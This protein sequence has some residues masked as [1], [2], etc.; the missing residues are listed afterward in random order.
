MDDDEIIARALEIVQARTSAK[1]GPT[2]GQIFELYRAEHLRAKSWTTREPRLRAFVAMFGARDA[3]G[4]RLADWADYRAAR[5]AKPIASDNP[6]KP[7]RYY[8]DLTINQELDWAKA[9]LNWAVGAGKLP[10][11][12]LA[13]AKRVKAPTRRQTS[14]GESDVSVFLA[15]LNP[16][17][18]VLVLAA[19]DAGM[20]RN[21]IRLLEWSWCDPDAAPARIHLPGW[22]TKNGKP[23]DVP[24]T[25]RLWAAIQAVPRHMRSP[26]VLTNLESGEPFGRNT[27][28][29]WF[30]EISRD[31][32]VKAAP[33][34]GNVHL[35]D[36]RHTF[37]TQTA[38]RIGRIDVVSKLL[39][40]ATLTQ[41][42]TYVQISDDD[43]E[44]ALSKIE[45]G[46]EKDQRKGP[47][48]S[49]AEREAPAAPA[50]ARP[51]ATSR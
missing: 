5:K 15:G 30:R 39:G 18:R 35:H 25:R 45:A 9:M 21:E 13:A 51:P 38:R 6:D 48:R 14:P 16:L 19:V 4:L 32:G 8:K 26:T 40:H 2:V 49:T 24:L 47:A 23:R 41:T 27:L 12:P 34:D 31:S 10:Y 11:N 22:A 7:K 28:S 20:R 3:M 43:M 42:Q 36:L 29:T 37:G 46:I 44:I 33:G 17:R 50:Q 1:A